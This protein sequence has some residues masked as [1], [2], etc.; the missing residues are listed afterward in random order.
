MISC[1]YGNNDMDRAEFWKWV[2]NRKAHDNPR[3][4]FIRDTRDLMDMDIDPETRTQR[5]WQSGGEI[6]EAYKGLQEEFRKE[7]NLQDAMDD[8]D[9]LDW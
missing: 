1:T 7:K 9:K 4:D 6:L 2:Y 8:I 5:I 3:G